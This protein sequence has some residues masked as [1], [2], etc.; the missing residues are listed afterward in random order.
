MVTVIDHPEGISFKVFVQPRSSKNMIAGIYGES[1]KI[2]LTAPPVDN[3]AN[4]MCV[5]FL[6][7]ILGVS[8][9]SVEILSGHTNRNKKI[10]VKLDQE[11]NLQKQAASLK[12]RIESLK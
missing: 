5:N 9:S 4:K 10:L 8:K 2:K 6:S 7:K 11:E 1:L 12:H 3:A